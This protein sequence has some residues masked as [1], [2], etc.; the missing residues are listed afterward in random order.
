ML[1]R[2]CVIPIQHPTLSLNT[3]MFVLQSES[4]VVILIGFM[5]ICS[6]ACTGFLRCHLCIAGCCQVCFVVL[7]LF[8]C[9]LDCVGWLA[10]WLAGWLV[11]CISLNVGFC[12]YEQASKSFIVFFFTSLI[13]SH[14]KEEE[15]K[16]QID[17]SQLVLHATKDAVTACLYE[18][19]NA[20]EF[21][22]MT[23]M[24]AR[25]LLLKQ[26]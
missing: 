3:D 24:K 21:F 19:S 7:D 17:M 14:L 4:F 9:L 10:G 15:R 25:F 20:F 6:R 12:F 2:D 13:R 5:S 23:T 22:Q 8:I 11:V 1:S 26:L 16:L 18:I